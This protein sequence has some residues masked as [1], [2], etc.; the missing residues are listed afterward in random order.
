MYTATY[1]YFCFAKILPIFNSNSVCNFEEK[2]LLPLKG[3]FP[4]QFFKI[5][6]QIYAIGPIF[7][8]F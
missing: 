3:D 6:K 8:K 2:D 1:S 5:S 4:P 7:S